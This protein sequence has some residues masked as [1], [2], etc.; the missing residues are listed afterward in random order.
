MVDDELRIESC[1]LSEGK[2]QEEEEAS[3][4]THVEPERQRDLYH[5]PWPPSTRNGA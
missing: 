3:A 1:V 4:R 2:A 5:V